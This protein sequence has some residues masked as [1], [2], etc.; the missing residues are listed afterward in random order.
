MAQNFWKKLET[1]NSYKPPNVRAVHVSSTV[2][3]NQVLY[4]GSSIGNGQ[5]ATDDLWFLDIKNQEEAN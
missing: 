4:Y 1:S 2:R 5:Y 3:E